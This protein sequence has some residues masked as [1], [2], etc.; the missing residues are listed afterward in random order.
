ME[1]FTSDTDTHPPWQKENNNL[2]NN[3]ATLSSIKCTV[4]NDCNFPTRSDL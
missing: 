1:Q 3:I 4:C 2:F